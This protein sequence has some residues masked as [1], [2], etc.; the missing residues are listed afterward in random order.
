MRTKLGVL[1]CLVGLSTI[2]QAGIWGNWI[3][4]GTSCNNFNVS[5]VE[6]GNSLS[7]LFDEF[8][9]YM[10]E[11]EIGD[12]TTARKTCNFRIGVTPPNGMYLASFRQTYSG[13]VIKSRN[14]SGQLNIRYNIGSVVGR[15]LPLVFRSGT[16]IR[17]ED[18]RSLFTET[19]NNNLLIANCGDATTYGL[20][21]NMTAT[22]RTA[23][24]H[25]ILGLDSVDADLIQRII[26]VPEFR[27]CPRR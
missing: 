10:P 4:G 27:L 7:V 14:S 11:D 25:L 16:E 18:S 6:N 1:A 5:V 24:D 20:N 2:A 21:M 22:R 26:L 23:R 3:A 13:G 17:P 9:V 12:G 8:G 19:Y 15:P